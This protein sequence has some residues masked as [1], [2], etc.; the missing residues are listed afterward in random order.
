MCLVFN[1]IYFKLSEDRSNED[2]DISRDDK[3]APFAY[4]LS[5]CYFS[6]NKLSFSDLPYRNALMFCS[7]NFFCLI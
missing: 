5:V 7:W 4:P 2:Q 6:A 3:K 1:S